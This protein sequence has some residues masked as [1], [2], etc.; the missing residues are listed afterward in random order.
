MVAVFLHQV[1][2]LEPVLLGFFLIAAVAVDVAKQV[3]GHV[4]LGFEVLFAQLFRDSQGTL[5]G[6]VDMLL[7]HQEHHLIASLGIVAVHVVL[8]YQELL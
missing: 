1:E 3:F 4:H 8:L 2:N 7:I 5:I 6:L